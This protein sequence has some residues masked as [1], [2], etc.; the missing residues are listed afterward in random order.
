MATIKKTAVVIGA[1]TG[2]YPCA[3]RLGQLGVDT[4]LIERDEPG[5]VC[6]NIG[7]IPSKALISASKLY[8]KAQHAKTMGI[9][10]GSAAVDMKQMQTWKAGV[11]KKLTTGVSGLVKEIG[12]AHV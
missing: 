10:F 12:R 1:G 6:L 4:M 2:G 11:V 3:I 9:A 8:H 7:C 5:G